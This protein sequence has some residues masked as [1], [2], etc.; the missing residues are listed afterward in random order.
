MSNLISGQ[1]APQTGLNRN[2]SNRLKRDA[3]WKQRVMQ[4]QLSSFF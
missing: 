3:V 1:L 4:D 2:R